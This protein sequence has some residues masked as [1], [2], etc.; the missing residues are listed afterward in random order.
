MALR[1]ALIFAG[2]AAA[3]APLYVWPG[4][5]Y[6]PG[7][8][9]SWQPRTVLDFYPDPLMRAIQ[10][11]ESSGGTDC[12]RGAAGEVGCWQIKPRT[13][14]WV[15]CP[16][17]W[18]SRDDGALARSCARSVLDKAR[19]LCARTDTAGLAHFYNRGRCLSWRAKPGAYALDVLNR[20]PRYL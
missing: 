19:A 6:A 18:D 1:S 8:L 9:V 13:A 12:R 4:A 10:D 16:A 7:S 5:A 3:L 15:G 20:L 11:M 14:L 2:F 17:G